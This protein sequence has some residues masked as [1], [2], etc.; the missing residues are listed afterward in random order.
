MLILCINAAECTT[1]E[2]C[3]SKYE[4]CVDMQY[5]EDDCPPKTRKG[6]KHRKKGKGRK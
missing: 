1:D 4:K 3:T 2:E 5:V 6:S